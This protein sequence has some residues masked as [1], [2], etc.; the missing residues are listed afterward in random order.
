VR[1]VPADHHGEINPFTKH[2]DYEWQSEFRLA[3][4]GCADDVLRL[5]L[6]SLKDI[7]VI[8]RTQE[9]LDTIEFIPAEAGVAR[10]QDE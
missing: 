4:F 9:V 5:E 2:V 8:G 10:R 1:Y 3:V 6:G 7:A